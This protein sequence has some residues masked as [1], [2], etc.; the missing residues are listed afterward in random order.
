MSPVKSNF[1][2]RLASEVSN[3]N[4][5]EVPDGELVYVA[6]LPGR[7]V[8]LVVADFYF[9]AARQVEPVDLKM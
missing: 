5:G 1:I 3:L 4:V 9:T 7:H 8:V 2:L 6:P